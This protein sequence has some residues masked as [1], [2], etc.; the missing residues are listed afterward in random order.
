MAV[1]VEEI[2][3]Y[4]VQL[5]AWVGP[6]RIIVSMQENFEVTCPIVKVI[7]DKAR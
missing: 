2:V 7:L 3:S 1:C 6:I 5:F 4:A